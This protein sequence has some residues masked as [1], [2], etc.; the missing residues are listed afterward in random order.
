LICGE[1]IRVSA[2]SIRRFGGLGIRYVA[3]P[4]DAR[5]DAGN[6]GNVCGEDVGAA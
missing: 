6:P 2:G 4:K 3:R 1:K 5:R